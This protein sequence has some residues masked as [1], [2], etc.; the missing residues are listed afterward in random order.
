MRARSALQ[1]KCSCGTRAGAASCTRCA[2]EREAKRDAGST[3]PGPGSPLDSAT[4]AVFEPRF[5][6]DFS[7]VR[8]H[9]G[10]KA[11]ASAEGLDA[12]AYTVGS[13]IVFGPGRYDPSTA[14]GRGLL[15]HE[16]A[17]TLQ[18]AAAPPRSPAALPVEPEGSPVERAAHGAARAVAAGR[19]APLLA[20]APAAVM[21]A[22]RSFFLTF[23]DGP[24]AAPLGGGSN[25]TEKVLDTLQAKGVGAGFFIQTAALDTK[26]HAMR[27]S[28]AVGKTLV[29]RM[30]AEGHLVGIHTGGTKDH[31]DHPVAEKAGRLAGEL[32]DAKDYVEKQTGAPAV[33]VRPPHGTTNAAVE[34]TYKSQGLT[35]VLWDIDG[36]QGKNL[37]LKDLKGRVDS[38]VRAMNASGW[39]L[40]TP[41]PHVVVLYHDIQKGTA[42]NIGAVIDHIKTATSKETGGADT[43]VF[44]APAARVGPPPSG[45]YPSTT[46]GLACATAC[47]SWGKMRELT[48]HICQLDG[49]SGPRCVANREKVAKA[50]ARILAADCRC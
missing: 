27:G 38:G 23:D 16:L 12:Q 5:G 25:R 48:D 33:A 18:Q 8:V 24:H 28:S 26:G 34:A 10:R 49:E 29:A 36:D 41:I 1:R 3:L 9:T 19:P 17:H 30:H 46:P 22:T 2:G 45:G 20:P 40:S 7:G 14:R 50:A 39:K 35:N 11:E 13:H 4:R 42:N 47:G 37:P 32:S 21:R 15:A 31:E 43:A 44:A 6:A